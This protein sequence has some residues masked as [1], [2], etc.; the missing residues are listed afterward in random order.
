MHWFLYR[1]KQRESHLF[2]LVLLVFQVICDDRGFP[3]PYTLCSVLGVA[4]RDL[5][6]MEI[7]QPSALK[8]SSMIVKTSLIK[9]AR[10][11]VGGKVATAANDITQE[12]QVV[13][14]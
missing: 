10:D 1:G 13:K 12:N 7:V 3:N 4:L 14:R 6:H 9:G 8:Q 11:V 5:G 2:Q